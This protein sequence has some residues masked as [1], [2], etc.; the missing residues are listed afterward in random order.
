MVIITCFVLCPR[1][2][3]TWLSLT[4][5]R[6]PALGR[7]SEEQGQEGGALAHVDQWLAWVQLPGVKR[8]KPAAPSWAS[9]H[10][11]PAE[12]SFMSDV[13][14]ATDEYQWL[15]CSYAVRVLLIA[16]RI[17]TIPTWRN[18]MSW[19]N[20]L[21]CYSNLD[22]FWVLSA[23]RLFISVLLYQHHSSSQ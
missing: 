16:V 13:K 14:L 9:F 17:R 8:P 5:W 7:L 1:G 6:P 15:A 18:V 23:A 10:S 19:G 20:I 11:F 21:Y 22:H 2:R 12:Q 3:V 4:G